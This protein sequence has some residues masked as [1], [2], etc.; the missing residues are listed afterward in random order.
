MSIQNHC[1]TFIVMYENTYHENRIM[2]L[3]A[4]SY[5]ACEDI[6]VARDLKNYAVLNYNDA[7]QKAEEI[8]QR[9]KKKKW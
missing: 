8:K 9:K 3:E 2:L 6:C 7:L 1:H 4:S 5:S